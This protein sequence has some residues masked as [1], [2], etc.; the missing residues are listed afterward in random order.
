LSA[1]WAQIAAARGIVAIVPDLRSDAARDDYQR[2][3]DHLTTRAAEYR[4]DRD[5]IAV[6]PG[7]GNVSTARRRLRYG[8]D[9]FISA[10]AP[11]GRRRRSSPGARA[12]LSHSARSAITGSILVARR[13]GNHD[14][15][16]VTI[17]RKTDSAT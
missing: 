12:I 11:N 8:R 10:A 1:S 2:L 17:R 4:L 14:A 3:V 13:A 9:Q 6:Y 5:A 15:H 16:S 7:S